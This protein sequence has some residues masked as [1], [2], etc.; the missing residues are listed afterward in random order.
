MSGPIARAG[1]V[2]ILLML[3][4]CGGPPWAVHSSPDA[5][6]LRWYPDETAAATAEQVAEAYCGAES[7]AAAIA[8]DQR[9]GSAEIA[10]YHC[11]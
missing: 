2:A 10:S 4:G 7:R 8:A 6:T 11:R 5:V 1:I 3:A 9:D